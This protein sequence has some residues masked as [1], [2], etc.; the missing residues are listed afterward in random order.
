VELVVDVISII[1]VVAGLAGFA[2][3]ILV[4]DG[5]LQRP[6][7][8]LRRELT[9]GL[10]VAARDREVRRGED[11]ETLVT[12]SRPRGLGDVEVGLICTEYYDYESTVRDRDGSTSSSRETAEAIA[13]EAWQAAEPVVGEQSLRFTV[14]PEAPFSYK[15]ECLSFKW[16]LVA[17]GRKRRRLDAQARAE[18]SVLP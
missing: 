10:E 2:Y 14:L 17:V 9:K 18:L 7:N 5:A 6:L 8:F 13:H 16:E 15:G 11:V 12:I 4:R 1:A 3:W